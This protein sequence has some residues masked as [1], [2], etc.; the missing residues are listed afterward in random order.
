ME[1]QSMLTFSRAS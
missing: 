1:Q